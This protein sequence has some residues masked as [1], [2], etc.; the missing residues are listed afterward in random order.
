M[1]KNKFRIPTAFNQALDFLET[2]NH[3]AVISIVLARDVTA[4]VI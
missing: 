2:C 4:V 3:S 1:M